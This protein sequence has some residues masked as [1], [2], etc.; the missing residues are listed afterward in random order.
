[1]CVKNTYFSI[2]YNRKHGPKKVKVV[3]KSQV[4]QTFRQRNTSFVFVTGPPDPV[5]FNPFFFPSLIGHRSVIFLNVLE[6]F[7]YISTLSLN[8]SYPFVDERFY[9]FLGVSKPCSK[10]IVNHTSYTR[11]ESIHRLGVFRQC[12]P[13]KFPSP[14]RVY[15]SSLRPLL[16]KLHELLVP[17]WGPSST[18][19]NP[20][21][22]SP[23]GRSSSRTGPSSNLPMSTF[24]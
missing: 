11:S 12:L 10:N 21:R 16:L 18:R 4:V 5:H 24:S 23:R 17:H 6:N 20:P 8:L 9:S 1:M 19:Y 3:R 13:R 22:L 15:E 14:L 7:L 2:S